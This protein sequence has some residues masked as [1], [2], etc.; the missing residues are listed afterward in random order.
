M[1]TTAIR[2]RAPYFL[3]AAFIISVLILVVRGEFVSNL[4]KGVILPEL[5]DA[6][7]QKVTVQKLYL[8][9][10]PL[11]IEANGLKIADGSGETDPVFKESEGIH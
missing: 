6:T 7:G 3:I 1:N 8:N 10:F 4:L 5:E 9:L 11:F 2:K